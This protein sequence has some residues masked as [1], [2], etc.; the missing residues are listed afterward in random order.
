ME[1]K[2]LPVRVGTIDRAVLATRSAD[3]LPAARIS[4][5]GVP[6]ALRA[7]TVELRPSTDIAC[8]LADKLGYAPENL[9]RASW[10]VYVVGDAQLY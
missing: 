9:W 6:M 4:F 2:S 1:R 10:C 3:C 5:A 7:L 8:C